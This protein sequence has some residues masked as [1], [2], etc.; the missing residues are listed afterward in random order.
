MTAAEK[1]RAALADLRADLDRVMR[2]LEVMTTKKEE[3]K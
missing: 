3:Q 2:C 1:L